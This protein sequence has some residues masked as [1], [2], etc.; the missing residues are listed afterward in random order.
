MILPR[1]NAKSAS[2]K[3]KA[4]LPIGQLV[5]GQE[6]GQIIH[7]RLPMIKGKAISDTLLII[8]RTGSGKSVCLRLIYYGISHLRPVWVFDY[9]GRD[10]YFSYMP[11]TTDADK[12]PPGFAPT[13]I[14]GKYFYYTM[15][16]SRSIKPWETRIRPNISKYSA[17][18]LE[19]LGFSPSASR[20]LKNIFKRYGP[21]KSI[22][23]LF[24][25]LENFP[26]NNYDYKAMKKKGFPYKHSKEYKENDHI[27][28]QSKDPLIRTMY[29][30]LNMNGFRTDN[31]MDIDYE[32]LYLS[33]QHV[34]FSYNNLMLARAEIDYTFNQMERLRNK[35]EDGPR[36]YI[37]IE[38][39]QHIVNETVG[40]FI[41]VCRKLSVGLAL[42]MP[43][44]PNTMPD[45]VL[46]DIKN[47]ICGKLKGENYNKIKALIADKRAEIIPSLKANL[48]TGQRE[49]LYYNGHYDYVFAPLLMYSS[50]QEM[51]REV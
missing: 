44:I 24:E 46:A 36:P 7:I 23:T 32:K 8:G 42:C 11:N 41:T 12:L 9:A 6:L 22:H 19:L 43:E 45:S 50:P 21:F 26:K 14:T 47:I 2:W 49:M 40:H 10:H 27:S 35:Y 16:N 1:N 51:H 48:Y 17:Y 30:L 28:S 18:Q 33:R 3:D 37:C 15:P 39:A 13:G 5:F 34:F 4:E 20:Y 38:E 29:G 25:F 31:K